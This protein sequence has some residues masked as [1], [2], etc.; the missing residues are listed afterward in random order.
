MFGPHHKDYAA[1][2]ASARAGC[3]LCHLINS[4]RVL[5]GVEESLPVNSSDSLHFQCR[6]GDTI[7]FGYTTVYEYDTPELRDVVELTL[8]AQYR[9]Y[10]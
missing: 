7:A 1:V 5:S 3:P 4:Y 9:K 10:S 2:A 8:A 6:W